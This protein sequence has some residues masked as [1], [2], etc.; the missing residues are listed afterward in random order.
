MRTAELISQSIHKYSVLGNKRQR[1]AAEDMLIDRIRLAINS[2]VICFK[3]NRPGHCLRII[4][5]DAAS[6]VVAR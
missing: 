3:D 5:E 1:Q 6:S 4:V 2:R